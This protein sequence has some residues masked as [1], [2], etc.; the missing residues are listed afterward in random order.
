MKAKA[1]FSKDFAIGEAEA[2]LYGSF[3]EHRGRAVYGGVYEPDHPNADSQGLRRDVMDLVKELQVSAVRYPGG[4]FVSA[5]DWRD[6]IGPKEKRPVRTELAWLS[7][8]TNQFG[9]DEFMDWCKKTG[10]EPMITVNLATRGIQEA[11]DIVEYCNFPA[12]TDLSREREKNG[13]KEPYGVKL[14]CL[15]N[16][17]DGEWQ[18]GQKTAEDYGEIAKQ[19]AKAMRAV[20]PDIEL[21][22]CYNT[23]LGMENHTDWGDRVLERCYDYID[24]ISLH[25]YCANEEKNT[26]DFLASTLDMEKYI[27]AAI[28]SCDR[29]KALA[30][31]QKTLYLSFDEW[32]V[33]YHSLEQDAHREKWLKGPAVLEDIYN[34][35]DAVVV[36]LNLILLLRHADRV[37]I[38]CLAQLVNV[39]APIFTRNGGE[40]IRQTIFY[41]FLQ[42]SRYGRGTVLRGILESPSYESRYGQTNYLDATAV[43]N[44]EKEEL[45]VFAVNRSQEEEMELECSLRDFASLEFV[46][47]LGLHHPDRYAE[48]T[49]EHP[50][51]CLPISETGT[52][53]EEGVLRA[54][55][56][57]LSWNV[58]RIRVPSE[59]K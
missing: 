5:Y 48:N 42:A 9:L 31:S 21:V 37:R 24:Y 2:R 49:L 26:G 38:G 19:A 58:I 46:E 13:H 11:R 34:V 44:E 29:A 20:D 27:E 32:N 1:V 8:E 45:T 56:A 28:A 43:Y 10:T 15:G 53:L 36:G 18:M 30:H 6:S 54:K 40:A 4:N 55:L 39:I 25:K 35:E 16:E 50:D 52:S 33:W 57:P 51:T 22:A 47:H 17:M 7:L 12:E 3:L 41:P 23:C 59:K 14:W